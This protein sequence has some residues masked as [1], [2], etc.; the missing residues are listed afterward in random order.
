MLIKTNNN[1]VL[2]R[3]SKNDNIG[4]N[5]VMEHRILSRAGQ[6]DA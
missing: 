2:I 5:S 4:H 1:G 3:N 6:L